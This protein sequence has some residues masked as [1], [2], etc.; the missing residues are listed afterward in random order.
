M[1]SSGSS[2][3]LVT[4]SRGVNNINRGSYW[5]GITPTL[6]LLMMG[7][8]VCPRTGVRSCDHCMKLHYMACT[9]I[10]V[11]LHLLYYICYSL[12]C[13]CTCTHTHT[14]TLQRRGSC[15]GRVY[16]VNHKS[17]TTQ[18]EDPRHSM[19]DQLPL[20]QGLEMRFTE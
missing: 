3:R 16:Y 1:S 12:I 6:T 11:V 15:H 4:S 8:G 7:R 18:W 10:Y 13:P 14:H 19:V 20:P 5:E 2:K 9:A 17:K